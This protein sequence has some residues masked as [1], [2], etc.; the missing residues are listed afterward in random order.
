MSHHSAEI[1]V[2]KGTVEL[3]KWQENWS[4]VSRKATM[5]LGDQLRKKPGTTVQIR[6]GNGTS[7][8]PFADD[9]PMGLFDICPTISRNEIDPKNPV[10]PYLVC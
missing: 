10:L 6:C 1:T 8:E 7:S 4:Q 3:R 2:G 9:M 5:Y